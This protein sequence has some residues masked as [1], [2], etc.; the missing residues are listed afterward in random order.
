M[1]A[2]YFLSQFSEQEFYEAPLPLKALLENSAY[3]P[4][5]YFDT[6]PIMVANTKWGHLGINSFIMCDFGVKVSEIQEYG[7]MAIDG[8]QCIVSRVISPKEYIP[9][10]WKLD[11]FATPVEKYHDRQFPTESRARRSAVWQIYNKCSNNEALGPE[12]ISVLF[13]IGEGFATYHQLYYHNNIAPKL[14]F[15]LQY[16]DMCGPMPNWEGRDSLFYRMIKTNLQC[17]PE[18]VAGGFHNHITYCTRIRNGEEFG[19]RMIPECE[20]NAVLEDCQ[21]RNELDK[22]LSGCRGWISQSGD[23]KIICIAASYIYILYE[24]IDKDS[25][26][27]EILKDLIL[28]PEQCDDF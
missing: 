22:T 14:L 26:V 20:H 9:K 8:Y 23:K 5:C 17:A 4:G 18:W 27:E 25:S 7:N 15:F 28:P 2:P 10:G 24:V 1:N 13:I 16:Y 6:F 3:Y 19:V 21:E 12:M 11:L